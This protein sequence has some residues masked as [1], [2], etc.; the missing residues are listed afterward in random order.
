MRS[1]KYLCNLIKRCK[2]WFMDKVTNNRNKKVVLSQTLTGRVEEFELIAVRCNS[3]SSGKRKM[4]PDLIY[5]FLDGYDIK[6]TEVTKTLERTEQNYL[7]DDFY[8]GTLKGKPH[9]QISAIVGQNGSGKSSIVEYVMRLVNNFASATLGEKKQGPAA[10]RLHYIDKVDGELWFALGSNIYHLTVK[11]AHVSLILLKNVGEK[12]GKTIYAGEKVVFDNHGDVECT[13]VINLMQGEENEA[14][15]KEI[16]SHF[17]YTLVSN[18][19]IYAYNTNDFKKECNSIAKESM[20]LGVKKD[21]SEYTV[22]ECNWLH[23][24]FHKNDGYQTPIVITP[25]RDNGNIEINKENYLAL[26][27]LVTLLARQ[28][29]L[30]IINGHLKAESLTYSYETAIYYGFRAVKSLGYIN[31]TEKGY[32]SLRNDIVKA[33]SDAVGE[34]IEKHQA[35]RAYYKQAVDYLVYKT[36]KISKQYKQHN[37]FHHIYSQMTDEYD[38]DAVK[39]LVQGESMDYSHITRKAMQTLAYFLFNIFTLEAK[40][41]EKGTLEANK[42]NMRFDELGKIWK[43]AT[44]ERKR[45]ILYMP[46]WS[47]IRM[48]ALTIPPFFSMRIN[49]CEADNE[50]VKIDFETLSSGEKQQIFNISSILYHLDNLDSASIDKS[51]ENRIVYHHVNVVLEEIE[52]YY[53]PEMQQQFVEYLIEGIDQ[54]ILEHINGIHV[55][56]VT[57]SPYVLSDIPRSNVLALKKDEEIP[58]K[59]LRTFGAN[60]HDMLKDSFFL[61]GG[62]IGNFAQWEVG[63]LMAVMKVYKWMD[64]EKDESV[65]CPYLSN[66][67]KIYKFLKRYEYVV[68]IDGKVEKRLYR[69][70]FKKDFSAG[71]LLM[72]IDLFDEPVLKNILLEE[73]HR[74]FPSFDKGYK[75]AKLKE[76][77]RQIKELEEE[78]DDVEA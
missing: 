43:K 29:G 56:I 46:L 38:K 2:T 47:H 22:E 68:N 49:L 10:T 13:E 61:Q 51:N 4:T 63:H 27:R 11:N 30:R 58:M 33:W 54:M 25:F 62:S 57:H 77:Y 64:E 35:D 42:T 74:T 73:F 21:G 66:G 5:Y 39:K 53:H 69:E 70:D 31:L 1:M 45:E 41:D 50:N 18:Q 9:L 71:R 12:E 55:M 34:D 48:C 14:K 16:Y 28:K 23:G 24:I 32:Q 76:L 15:L 8:S 52:L 75:A 67:D 7:Y 6:P 36:L 26:E 20:A 19:S 3:K 37:D 65:I 78:Q 60:I 17:F 44:E 72:R 59:G 40:Y